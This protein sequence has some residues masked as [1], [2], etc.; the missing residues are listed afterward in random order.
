[1][2]MKMTKNQPINESN[3]YIISNKH[4]GSDGIANAGYI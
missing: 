4:H 2:K 1:M 3:A